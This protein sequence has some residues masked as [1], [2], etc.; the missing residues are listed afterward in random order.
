MRPLFISKVG[1]LA[2]ELSSRRSSFK[3]DALDCLSFVRNV[4][5]LPLEW[6]ISDSA[7]EG[8]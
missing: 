8:S 4:R 5:V 7:F 2:I 1:V 3:K 6:L